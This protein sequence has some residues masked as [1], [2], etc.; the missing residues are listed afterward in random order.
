MYNAE[1]IMAN[2]TKEWQKNRF[3]MMCPHFNKFGAQ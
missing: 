2:V 1:C 3:I